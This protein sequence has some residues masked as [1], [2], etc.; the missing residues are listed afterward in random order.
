MSDTLTLRFLYN[1]IPGRAILKV[2]VTPAVSKAGGVL[3]SSGFSKLFI[4]G[5]I[6]KHNIDMSA[7]DIPK[8]GFPS[9]NAFFK[10][11]RKSIEYDLSPGRLISPC[12]AFLTPAVIRDGTV[13]DIKNSRYTVE[14]LLQDKELAKEFENGLA[15]IFR[16]TPANYHRY[17]FAVSGFVQKSRRIDGELHCVRPVALRNIPVHARNSREYVVVETEDFGKV[18]QMEVGALFVGKIQ[19]HPLVQSGSATASEAAS[20][21]A[22]VAASGPASE[23]AS[24]AA[25]ESA[26]GFPYVKAGDEKGFFEFGGSTIILLLQKDAVDFDETLLS[27][28]DENDE[29]PV[30]IGAFIANTKS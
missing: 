21:S 27:P 20:E 11:K 4:D 28:R 13:L 18:V 17:S 2:L 8:E 29:I 24:E 25:S 14:D 19:N 15:L 7:T 5:F 23:A 1:T 3:L 12:E 22:S 30:D 16:L 10:R 26:A 9:F 6:K